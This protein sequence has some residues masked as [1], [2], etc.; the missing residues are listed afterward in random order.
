VSPHD[1]LG[2][3]LIVQVKGER[4]MRVLPL[5][6]EA[7]NECWISDKDRFAYEGLNSSERLTSPMIKQDGEWKTV[8]WQTA[9][10]FVA[11]ALT[12]VVT[13]HGA[14]ALG[15]FVSPH[16]TLE[17]L[18]LAGRLVRG[19]G[20]DNIDFRLRQ[21]DFRGDGHAQ[22]VPW[23]GLPV[24]DINKLDRVL[25]VGS[26]LRKD[27]PL[28]AQRLRQAAKKGTQVSMLHSVDDEWLMRMTHKVIVPPSKLPAALAGV[29]VAAA[30]AGGSTVPEILA[31]ITPT[32]ADQAI[33]ASLAS[34]KKVAVLL[35]N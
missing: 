3:N 26:F 25:V 24:A 33:A 19:L 22:G 30:Q 34:G 9:L 13:R 23:L 14:G 6:N 12:D 28:V 4:V 18:T 16:A 2:S 29:V 7:V 8:D 15:A 31:D 11:R 17:E 20:S 10:E 27:H 32:E 21:S 5:E 1:S 35:G